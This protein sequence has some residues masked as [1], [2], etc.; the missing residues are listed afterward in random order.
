MGTLWFWAR[1]PEF[2]PESGRKTESRLRGRIS[3]Y[4]YAMLT[5]TFDEPSV[6]G[7]LDAST[8]AS[9]MVTT[10]VLEQH[11]TV[12]M[13]ELF[14]GCFAGWSQSAW[15]MQT[16]GAP[17]HSKRQVDFGSAAHDMLACQQPGA[18]KVE[19]P[20]EFASAFAS[21]S[22]VQVQADFS[23]AWWLSGA[24]HAPPHLVTVSAPCP[25]WSKAANQGA[26]YA[27]RQAA[28]AH[29]GPHGVVVKPQCCWLKRWTVS[30]GARAAIA[31]PWATN[32][33][34]MSP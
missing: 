14:S 31:R 17:I 15:I 20:K 24:F 5:G 11:T 18:V 19:D 4:S 28:P 21:V 33:K 29:S 6:K 3:S 12:V 26:Q 9:V 27:R 30:H 22:A 1:S 16:L 10:A 23:D 25:P 34:F 2:G 32:L 7:M 13:A 8:P